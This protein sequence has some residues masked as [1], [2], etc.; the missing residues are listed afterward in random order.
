MAETSQTDIQDLSSDKLMGRFTRSGI[1][2]WVI[3]AFALHVVV[4]GGT[5]VDY[6]HGVIDPTWKQQQDRVKEEARNKARAAELAKTPR[7][8][9]AGPITTTRPAPARPSATKP[10]KPGER[11][12]PKELTSKPKPGEIP[13][14]PGAG[15]GLDETD[16]R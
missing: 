15:I 14:A 11:K 9:T 5:S 12:L 8:R 16:K 3:A 7:K 4:L 2:V 10:A 13:K 1:V 6:I